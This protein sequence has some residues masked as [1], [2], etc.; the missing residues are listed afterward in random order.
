MTHYGKTN[1]WKQLKLNFEGEIVCNAHDGSKIASL[2]DNRPIKIDSDDFHGRID[3]CVKCFGYFNGESK[4]F[5]RPNMK[6]SN[7]TSGKGIFEC[8]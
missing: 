8:F 4:S 2:T 5:K 1:I 6:S 3:D 7:M